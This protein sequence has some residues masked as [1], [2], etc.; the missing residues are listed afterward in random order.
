M[1]CRR[2]PRAGYSGGRILFSPFPQ[3]KSAHHRS[4][5]GKPS[6]AKSKHRRGKCSAQLPFASLSHS[7][8]HRCV[9]FRDP[10]QTAVEWYA[11]VRGRIQPKLML[12][13]QRLPGVLG[14][15]VT[16]DDIIH[17]IIL[18][19]WANDLIS[20]EGFRSMLQ[21]L[22][23]SKLS[24]LLKVSGFLSELIPYRDHIDGLKSTS[25]SVSLS[26][27]GASIAVAALNCVPGS[28]ASES[29]K[30]A[31]AIRETLPTAMPS[32]PVTSVQ[33]SHSL[34]SLSPA[35]APLQ[36]FPSAPEASKVWEP[37]QRPMLRNEKSEEG[38]EC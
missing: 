20:I 37:P 13:I 24:N 7:A 25:P 5:S 14:D 1:L 29:A 15:T 32:T 33:A 18:G 11:P 2:R 9:R 34:S 8:P 10:D 23:K 22:G 21:R 27:S 17:G 38:W 28:P 4:A 26:R 31:I 36:A 6:K 19:P 35:G 12:K 3:A 16:S 30:L